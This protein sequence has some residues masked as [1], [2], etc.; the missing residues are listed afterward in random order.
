MTIDEIRDRILSGGSVDCARRRYVDDVWSPSPAWCA[1]LDG[2][3]PRP[4]C[5]EGR[6]TWTA[7][8]REFVKRRVPT[9]QS[10]LAALGLPSPPSRLACMFE[11]M[12][13]RGEIGDDGR[14]L[15]KS[16]PGS[17]RRFRAW[18]RRVRARRRQRQAHR[19]R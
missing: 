17:D 12:R 9:C 14:L 13:L 3:A 5:Q 8:Y 7:T 18:K 6:G 19:R 11:G 1:N 16:R 15:V 4:L 10:C 2:I